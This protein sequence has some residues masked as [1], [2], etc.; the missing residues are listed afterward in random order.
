MQNLSN[1][2]VQERRAAN[3]IW[4]TAENYALQPKYEAFDDAGRA[5]LYFN[6]IIGTLYRYYDFPQ[7][8]RLF[9]YFQQK[10]DGAL[11]TDLFWIGLENCA[12]GRAVTERP[13]LRE[14]RSQYARSFLSRRESRPGQEL[15]CILKAAHLRRALGQ[16]VTGLTHTEQRL[17]SALEFSPALS[18]EEIVFQMEQVL[19]RFF[20]NKRFREVDDMQGNRVNLRGGLR[21]PWNIRERTSTVRQLSCSNDSV[22][23]GAAGGRRVRSPL[24]FSKP[25]DSALRSY[26]S[27][28]FGP[29]MFPPADTQELEQ[30]LC[31][32]NHADC[33]LHFTRGTFQSPPPEKEAE[34]RLRALTDA[35]R[36]ENRLYFQ[37]H[38]GQNRVAVARLTERIRNAVALRMEPTEV[39][40]RSG[41]FQ[42]GRVWRGIFLEDACVFQKSFPSELGDLTVDILLD[43]S[44]SQKSQQAQVANQGYVIAESL[45]RCQIPVRVCAFCAVSGCTVIQILRDYGEPDKN[46]RIL[47]YTAVGWNRDGLALRA[48]GHL[49]E[50]T[51]GGRRLLIILSDVNPNDDQKLPRQGFLHAGKDYSG[52]LGVLDV[53][54]EA[55]ALRQKG[56]RVLCVF[57]GGD[58]TLPGA[59]KI[60]GRDLARIHS[61]N[62]FADT[63]GRLIQ[64]HIQEM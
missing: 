50:Q 42:A 3:L 19:D 8:E 5:D 31:T 25:H 4:N 21:L 59:R 13:V 44:A 47:D 54:A 11:Y 16:P 58:G 2:E 63:V 55:R 53:A 28:C 64:E 20:L 15:A 45:T 12:Y 18:T 27:S 49:M 10:P 33:H 14:L 29:C 61:V 22:S 60:Y 30:G 41:S 52:E 7:F 35:Q 26:V 43:G 38:A 48:V 36:S 46:Q 9:H 51:H 37:S 62:F 40:A 32:G 24:W 17:L 39:H 56:I 23:H 1:E 34:R 57:T 6:S